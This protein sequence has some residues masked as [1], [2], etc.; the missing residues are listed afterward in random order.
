MEE[1][2]QEWQIK[3]DTDLEAGRNEIQILEAQT[4]EQQKEYIQLKEE[5]CIYYTYNC[6]IS[7]NFKLAILMNF[8]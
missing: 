2:L 4:E 8:H 3:Y 1:C 5:V 7:Y 6:F